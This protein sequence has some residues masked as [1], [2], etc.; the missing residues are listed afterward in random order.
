M[1]R[2]I[3]KASTPEVIRVHELLQ[4]S[5]VLLDAV[6]RDDKRLVRYTEG[7]NDETIAKQVA[8]DLPAN[9]VQRIRTEM[10]G[11]LVG[12]SAETEDCSKFAKRLNRVEDRV[13]ALLVA[14]KSLADKLGETVELV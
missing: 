14:V 12:G 7:L 1:P 3:R 2:T 4:K 11:K 13:S 10:F 8:P 6:D 9:V 5:L